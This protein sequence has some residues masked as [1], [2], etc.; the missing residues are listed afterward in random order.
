MFGSATKVALIGIP[1]HSNKGDSAITVAER[2]LLQSLG[3]EVCDIKNT[4][5]I[6]G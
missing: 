3:I 2:A 6:L 5:P 1:D 4:Y